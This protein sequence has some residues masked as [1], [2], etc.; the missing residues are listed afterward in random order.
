MGGL[1]CHKAPIRQPTTPR[2]QRGPFPMLSH[3]C[4][5]GHRRAATVECGGHRHAA[6]ADQDKSPKISHQV[7]SFL[8][9]DKTPLLPHS[10][11][12]P[13]FQIALTIARHKASSVL[14][15]LENPGGDRLAVAMNS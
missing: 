14:G 3:I 1:K 10:Q 9:V 12:I 13:V 7:N 5:R 6:P 4:S 2:T 8:F 15:P 11:R